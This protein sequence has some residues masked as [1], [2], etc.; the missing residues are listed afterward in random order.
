MENVKIKILV[1][2]VDGEV[3]LRFP[4]VSLP[5]GLRHEEVAAI[6]ASNP[7]LELVDE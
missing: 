4:I 2:K 6:I 7:T 1:I 3:A 5:D